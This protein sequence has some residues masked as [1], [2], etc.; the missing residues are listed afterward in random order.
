M[1]LGH[2][3]WYFGHHFCTSFEIK[4][5]DCSACV[6][7]MPRTVFECVCGYKTE[8]HFA[9]HK[10]TCKAAQVISAQNEVLA[11]KDE[12]LQRKDEEIQR[13]AAE[14]AAEREK[15]KVVNHITNHNNN[16]SITN[17]N[18]HLVAF[19]SEPIPTR[20]EVL[21]SGILNAPE[22]SIA[23]YI[24]MKHFRNAETAN[25]RLTNKRARTMQVVEEDMSRE[26]RWTERDKADM[27]DTL[28]VRNMEELVDVHEA[29]RHS[30]WGRWYD[31]LPDEGYDKT[32]TWRRAVDN[33]EH[34]LL[35]RKPG[36]RV[37]E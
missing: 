29:R 10:S 4:F 36:N 18:V 19:G 27:I 16:G 21:R 7:H 1:Y 23:R 34:M 32:A 17:N 20:A 5:V 9:R 25:L 24:E 15:P 2:H 35:S 13:L 26:L 31:A 12:E 22:R 14:L 28:A 33:I 37:H 6:K 30:K 8:R 11:G 3:F